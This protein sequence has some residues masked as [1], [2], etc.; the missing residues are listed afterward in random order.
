MQPYREIEVR[1]RVDENI[2]KI[3]KGLSFDSFDQIDEYFFTE[4][5]IKEKNMWLRLRQSGG[6]FSLELK[7]TIKDAFD[8]DK[9]SV[10]D[11]FFSKIDEN[12]YKKIREILCAV[13]PTSFKIKKRRSKAKLGGCEICHD[14]VDGLGNFIE[15]EGPKEKIDEVCEKFNINMSDALSGGYAGM[16]IEKLKL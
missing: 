3:I 12:Q 4:K 14:V 11:E 16:M 8:S 15:I 2:E 5:S 7:K 6:K 9:I 1:F 13:F 10:H